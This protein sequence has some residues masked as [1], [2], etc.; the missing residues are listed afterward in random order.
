MTFTPED[1]ES[2]VE[3]E[4]SGW[5]RVANAYHDHWGGLSAQSALPMLQAARVGP[6]SRVLD[7]ATG[8]GYVAATAA[9]LGATA[10]GLDFSGAQIELAG[11]MFPQLDF[12]RG[13]AQ[14]LSFEDETFDA[15]V[16][17]FGMNHLPHPEQ[18]AAEAWRVL[19]PGGR[20]AFT[21]W[22]TPKSGEGFG[23]VTSSIETNGIA[24]PDLPAAPPLF[25]F[26]EEGEVHAMLSEV[27]FSEISTTIV[28]QYWRH[29]T[30]DQLLDA[31]S[32]GAVRAAMLV[33]SQPLHV[34]EVIR[35]EV[36]SQVSKLKRGEEYVI[37]M[38]AALSVGHKQG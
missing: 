34:Q 2:F 25:R 17:G 3:F 8:A 20:Y 38:P 28:P 21:V 23:I 10:T 1:M 13:D 14:E 6:G 24:N 15:V 30:P 32:E 16:M 22:A 7:V 37:P 26:A 33:K 31:F 18:A 29:S 19:K 27:G 5:E 36:H 12:Q 9:E 35:T 4:K 11:R